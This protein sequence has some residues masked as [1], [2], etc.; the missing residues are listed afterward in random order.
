MQQLPFITEWNITDFLS[1]WPNR[2]HLLESVYFDIK[3]DVYLSVTRA[4]GIIGKLVTEP[5]QAILNSDIS[6]FQ[7]RSTIQKI[8]EIFK[9]WVTD[10]SE[11]LKGEEVLSGCRSISD[12][13][14]NSLFDVQDSEFNSLTSLALEVITASMLVIL[15]RQAVDHLQMQDASTCSATPQH[16]LSNYTT[17]SFSNPTT[18]SEN[19]P[20]FSN[21]TIVCENPPSFS[22]PTSVCDNPSFSNPIT[23]CENP[24]SFFNPTTVSSNPPLNVPAT[25]MISER[26]MAKLD[27]LLRIKPSALP[28]TIEAIVMWQS[29]KPSKWINT[30]PP[31]EKE[32]LFKSAQKLAPNLRRT[33]K[34]WKD[35][36]K[37]QLEKKLKSKQAEVKNKEEKLVQSKLVE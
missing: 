26:D 3:E 18:V 2:N 11:A 27:N 12:E 1:E 19:P 28:S 6:L 21:P 13:V 8:H 9:L 35:N 22:N 31:A 33:M 24:P 14:F 36:L 7:A 15:E 34:T 30:L 25:N 37:M 16:V 17:P 20:C 23:V 5:L 4:L 10:G 29:N 32:S